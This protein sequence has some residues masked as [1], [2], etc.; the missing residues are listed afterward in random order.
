MVE[1]YSDPFSIRTRYMNDQLSVGTNKYSS[2]IDCFVKTVRAEG[3][4][5]LYKGFTGNYARLGPHFVI[6]LPLFEAV[7]TMLGVGTL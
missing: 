2:S 5:S 6:S 3:V 1:F 7:R 4:R